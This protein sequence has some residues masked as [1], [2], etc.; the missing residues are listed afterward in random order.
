MAADTRNDCVIKSPLPSQPSGTLTYDI[1]FNIHPNHHSIHSSVL[2]DSHIGFAAY[3]R[4][5][6]I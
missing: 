2:S 3:K 4:A 1:R 6:Y 5:E